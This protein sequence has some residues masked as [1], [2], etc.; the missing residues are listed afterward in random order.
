MKQIY[1]FLLLFVCVG[2]FATG[3]ELS[4]Q[5]LRS[6]RGDFQAR[7]EQFITTEAGLTPQESE[8]FFPLFREMKKQQMT[9]FLEQRRLRHIDMNDSKA[10]EEAVLKRAANEVKIKEIQQTYYQKFL[11]VLP[12]NKVFLIVK[13]EKKFHRQL[14]QRHALKYFKKRNDKR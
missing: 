11:K 6:R 8:V 9:Y 4:E 12:A 1:S 13:A 5:S 3:T 10:C 7:M 2:A 14:M